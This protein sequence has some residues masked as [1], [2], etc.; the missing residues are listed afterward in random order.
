MSWNNIQATMPEGEGTNLVEKVKISDNN[1]IWKIDCRF[2]STI[3]CNRKSDNVK[4]EPSYSLEGE[5]QDSIV[6]LMPLGLLSS[7]DSYTMTIDIKN[8]NKN[9][10]KGK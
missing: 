5:E 7:E 4:C 8:I 9:E 6:W 2:S 1:Q 3:D 10:K